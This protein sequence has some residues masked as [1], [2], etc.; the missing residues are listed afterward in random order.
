L[1]AFDDAGKH[2]YVEKPLAATREEGER[3]IG[4]ARSK[5]LLVG[6]APDTFL[7]GGIQTCRK[8]IE[9]GVIGTPVAAT[10]SMMSKGHESS[11]A[12]IRRRSFITSLEAGRCSIWDR[13]T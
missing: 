5:G 13:I 1:K 4:L 6:S 9:D 3:I 10:G 11:K 2:V 12:G 7:G 8:L